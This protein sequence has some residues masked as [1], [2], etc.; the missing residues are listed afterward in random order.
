[1]KKILAL[2]VL[3]I[4]PLLAS[5]AASDDVCDG[6]TA[7]KVPI[8]AGTSEFI[9]RDFNAQCSANVGLSYAQNATVIAVAAAS[10]KGKTYF[11]GSSEGGAVTKDGTTDCPNSGCVITD[12]P[13]KATA[14][15]SAS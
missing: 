1:M 12:L 6:T 10:A 2:A 15:L 9:K 3:A 5:A 11:S 14:K 8:T 7:K 13:G 4:S